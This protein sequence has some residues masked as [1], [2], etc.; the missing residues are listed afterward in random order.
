M[1]C[2]FTAQNAVDPGWCNDTM[3]FA[4]CQ[5]GDERR[6]CDGSNTV[7]SDIGT[8]GRLLVTDFSNHRVSRNSELCCC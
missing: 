4:G 2:F 6:D 3:G 1:F 8:A 5:S 7:A